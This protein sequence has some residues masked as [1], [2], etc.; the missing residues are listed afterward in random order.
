MNKKNS[1]RINW[2]L[3]LTV[4]ALSFA[5]VLSI[6][7]NI[8][9]RKALDEP[10]MT[11]ESCKCKNLERDYD[12]GQYIPKAFRES[13]F[14]NHF[15]YN[16]IL[17]TL[18]IKNTGKAAAIPIINS[19]TVLVFLKTEAPYRIYRISVSGNLDN[20]EWSYKQLYKNK[21]SQ[22]IKLEINSFIPVQEKIRI[23]FLYF[24]ERGEEEQSEV[25][26]ANE[27]LEEYF[28]FVV[29]SPMSKYHP[30]SMYPDKKKNMRK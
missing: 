24:K 8:I 23:N 4:V 16:K 1:R 30:P 12:F 2:S 17:N 7:A 19:T 3:I 21:K 6:R 9:A 27:I 5:T 14:P 28:E 29:W 22:L 10:I 13:D 15:Y 20:D 18:D 26:K 25:Q 11:I